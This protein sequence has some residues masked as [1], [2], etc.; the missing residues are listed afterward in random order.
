MKRIGMKG[1]QMK[2]EEYY[3]E[4]SASS[5]NKNNSEMIE[6]VDE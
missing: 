6:K 3:P 4:C 2:S 5:G 1:R